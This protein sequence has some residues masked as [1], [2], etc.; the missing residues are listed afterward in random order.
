MA[1]STGIE[2]PATT[3]SAVR[4]TGRSN[5]FRPA[6]HRIGA[7]NILRIGTFVGLL[8]AWEGIFR[9]LELANARRAALL[10]T[11]P[12]RMFETLRE[13]V[14]DGSLAAAW[15]E[16]LFVLVTALTLAAI[17]GV[18]LG[19]LLGR[20]R[21]ASDL[22]ELELT[23]LFLTPRIALLPLIALWFGFGDPAKIVV[24]FLFAFFEIFFNVRNGVRAVDAEFIEVAR[25]YCIPE[26]V[27]LTKVVV[28]AALPYVATGL[29]LGLLH[30]MVGVVLVGF[31][32][33]NNGIGGL[34]Y[35]EAQD[36]RIAG[37]FAG[38]LTVALVGMTLNT[39]LRWVERRV[40]PW[41]GGAA[42]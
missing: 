24:V 22:F 4:P 35:N 19:I 7:D 18:T 6:L 29:R 16:T 38:L 36:F 42:T 39:S 23:A 3:G 33:E 27:M 25:A 2:R 31:F 13:M 30:G 32:L 28:P 17:V 26:R 21:L 12:G 34:L 5:P 1:R 10:F 41:R 15:G 11:S 37:L 14:V 40:A 9:L 8:A 20:F